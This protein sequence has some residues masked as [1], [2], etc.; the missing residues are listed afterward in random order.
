MLGVNPIVGYQCTPSMESLLFLVLQSKD[1]RLKQSIIH[2]NLME[3][4]KGLN[5]DKK[6]IKF[7]IK[8]SEMHCEPPT[9]YSSAK[10]KF[11][12]KS[13]VQLVCR[14]EC[15]SYVYNLFNIGDIAHFKLDDTLVY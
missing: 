7:K 12:I 15:S 5:I 6:N 1:P 2:K 14:L 10:T 9:N 8:V 3:R 4:K 13:L 11:I